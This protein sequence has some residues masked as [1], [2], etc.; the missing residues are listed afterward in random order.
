VTARAWAALTTVYV[1]WG[2]TYLAIMVAIRTLPPLLMSS[3]RY[4]VAGAVLY[5]FAAR[6]GAARP[7]LRHWRSAVVAGAALLLVGNGGVAWSEQRIDSGVAALLIATVPLWI[8]LFD[9]I[10]AGQRLAPS[11][12]LGL[13][14]GLGGVVLLVGPVGGGGID[15]LGTLAALVAALAWAGGSLYARGAAVPGDL[16][17]GAAMQM[18]AGGALLAVAGAAGGEVADV[19]APS[20]ASLGALAYLVVVGSLVAYSAYLWLMRSAPTSIVSTYAFVNP[21]IAV[22]LG[23]VFLGEP[24]GL[25]ILGASAAIVVSVALIVTARRAAKPARQRALEPVRERA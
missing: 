21:A 23:A 1:V 5:A 18:L 8:A 10:F 22:A 20:L 2:S 13:A 3:I 16:L 9:R 25:R 7:S 24:L 11:G 17:L 6:R 12:L 15:A 19:H 4:L 14:V